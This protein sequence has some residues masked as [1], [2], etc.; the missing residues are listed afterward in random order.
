VTKT[1]AW[2]VLRIDAPFLPIQ[3]GVVV[4][5]VYDNEADAR[6][7]IIRAKNQNEKPEYVII[8]TRH[9][10][11]AEVGAPPSEPERIQGFVGL[12]SGE[13]SEV[14]LPL[15]EYLKPIAGLV[16]DLPAIPR[17]A[18]NPLLAHV[19]ERAVVSTV[20]GRLGDRPDQGTDVRLPDGRLIEV[21]SVWL[22][23]ELRKAPS[24]RVPADWN[25][26]LLAVV[27]FAPDLRSASMRFLPREAVEL[28]SRPVVTTAGKSSAVLRITPQLLSWPRRVD[29]PGNIATDRDRQV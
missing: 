3:E 18:L 17:S 5:G 29:V 1:P 14:S 4:K 6:D 12:G 19:A 28:Y 24:I 26:D 25:F 7:A 9:F 11:A 21:K 13:T 15:Q 22:D 16:R 23:P 10:S 27:L 8:R 2:V 20:G